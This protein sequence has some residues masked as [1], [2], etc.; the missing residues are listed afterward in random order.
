MAPLKESLRCPHC[1]SLDFGVKKPGDTWLTCNVCDYEFVNADD[2]PEPDP[3]SESLTE[4][5]RGSGLTSGNA[6]GAGGYCGRHGLF[7]ERVCPVCNK[8]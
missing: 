5:A 6:M 4:A 1:G 2:V 8:K 7:T 3:T